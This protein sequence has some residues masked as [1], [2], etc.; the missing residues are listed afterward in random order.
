MCQWLEAGRIVGFCWY[1]QWHADLKLNNV[2]LLKLVF[3]DCIEIELEQLSH[4]EIL[5]RAGSW[6]R[7]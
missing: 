1:E 6:E 7:G 3:L 4:Q 2:G 5:S